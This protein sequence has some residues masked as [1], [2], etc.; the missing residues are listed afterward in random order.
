MFC[1][2]TKRDTLI[3]QESRWVP[4]R[5]NGE[6]RD[7]VPTEMTEVIPWKHMEGRN[8]RTVSLFKKFFYFN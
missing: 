5:T 4:K 3:R 2:V 8:P 1:L 7:W 6:R